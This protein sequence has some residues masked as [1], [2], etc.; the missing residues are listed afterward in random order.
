MVGFFF[1]GCH[2]GI[3]VSQFLQHL[4]GDRKLR[5]CYVA[6]FGVLAVRFCVESQ[7]LHFLLSTGVLLSSFFASPQTRKC[8]PSPVN[9]PTEQAV[10]RS[11]S[12][13]F[14]RAQISLAWVIG[15]PLAY[16]L[17]MGF[18]FKVTHLTAASHLLFAH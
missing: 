2:H 1:T 6:D 17:A 8:S 4:R 12:V 11:C 18:S 7:L 15:P 5:F 9:T 16:E 13:A 10:R 3:L 14:L